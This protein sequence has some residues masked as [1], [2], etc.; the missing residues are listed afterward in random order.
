MHTVLIAHS[1]PSGP[2]STA[3]VQSLTRLPQ[4]EH[5]CPCSLS[6]AFGDW[7]GGSLQDLSR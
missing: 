6:S 4:K 5:C 3:G 1:R 2:S 7:K